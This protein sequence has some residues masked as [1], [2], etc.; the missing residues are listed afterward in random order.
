MPLKYKGDILTKLKDAGYTSYR[1]RKEGHLSESTIQKLRNGIGVSWDNLETICCLMN[2]RVEDIIEY[3]YSETDCVKR[4]S[5]HWVDASG[6]NDSDIKP[7]A[8]ESSP[9]SACGVPD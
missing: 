1:L 2:C 6:S 5:L 9:E 7:P 3:Q 4:G 8:C